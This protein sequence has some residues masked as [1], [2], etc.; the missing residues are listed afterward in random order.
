M[1]K[2]FLKY[3]GGKRQLLPELL[4]RVPE[5]FGTYYEPFVGGGA[6]FFAMRAAGKAPRAVL[7]DANCDL[8]SCYAA[9]R[10]HPEELVALLRQLEQQRTKDAYLR[11][12]DAFNARAL[13]DLERPAAFLYFNK[14]GF[15]GL[16]RYNTQGQFN[17]PF[18]TP[19]QG[20]DLLPPEVIYEA[21]E[22]LQGVLLKS[23]SY[24]GILDEAQAGDFIYVD[25]PYVPTSKTASFTGYVGRP[26]NENAHRGLA[27]LLRQAAGR[28]VH[29]LASNADAP[30]VREAY[31]GWQID[32]VSA[33]R[34]INCKRDRRGAVGEVLIRS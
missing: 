24:E 21:S 14:V 5:I 4:A 12:R 18:G 27:F 20:K 32:V 25:P 30:L 33:R 34:A 19:R 23:C 17:V 16:I 7:A 29:V 1:A 3:V 9:V 6:L 11:I 15:N 26:W 31:A 13:G 10:D 2:P 8:I 22:A 28:G